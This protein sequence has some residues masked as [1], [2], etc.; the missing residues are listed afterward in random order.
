MYFADSAPR[1]EALTS[2]ETA[3]LLL[4]AQGKGIK[5][6]A[7][8]LSISPNTVSGHRK[9]ICK[10]LSVHSTAELVAHAAHYFSR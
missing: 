8:N 6:I 10:K 2:R 9:H 5:E 3:I 4:I 1:W 7:K